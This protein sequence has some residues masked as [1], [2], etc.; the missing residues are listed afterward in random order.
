M[1][2][3]KCFCVFAVPWFFSGWIVTFGS[4]A[5][6]VG[7]KSWDDFSKKFRRSGSLELGLA[8]CAYV[9]GLVSVISFSL[10]NSWNNWKCS[11]SKRYFSASQSQLCCKDLLFPQNGFPRDSIFSLTK[12][13]IIWLSF[14]MQLHTVKLGDQFTL[15]TEGASLSNGWFI[16][17]QY[18]PI[19]IQLCFF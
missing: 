9:E 7:F 3:S 10:V 12:D 4:I 16:G 1:L 5:S 11:S 6:V 13:R 8:T 2:T 14:V 15:R 17:G 19:E 18:E